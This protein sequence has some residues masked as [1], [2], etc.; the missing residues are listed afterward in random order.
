[1]SGDGWEAAAKPKL[2]VEERGSKSKSKF[3]LVVGKRKYQ[4]ELIAPELIIARYFADQQAVIDQLNDEIAAFEQQLDEM[5]EEHGGEDGLLEEA[6]NDKDK[7]TKATVTARLKA[8][9]GETDAAEERG[10]LQAYLDIVSKQSDVG[11]KLKLAETK[12]NEA[13]LE[14]Y[15]KLTKQDIITLVVDD[16]WLATLSTAVQS[17]LDRVSQTLTSRIREIAERYE[18]PL[19]TL[20]SEVSELS[21][22]VDQHLKRMVSSWQ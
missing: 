21:N 20:I 12:L 6:K 13:V 16:K 22:R 3:D 11:D 4:T 1:V 8:I 17:E 10:A 7:I 5:T 14:R 18:T 2:I 9:R 19:P 15:G